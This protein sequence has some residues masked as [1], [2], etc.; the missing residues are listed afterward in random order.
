MLKV[1]QGIVV[2]NKFQA[3]SGWGSASLALAL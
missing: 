3:V 2:W 1:V